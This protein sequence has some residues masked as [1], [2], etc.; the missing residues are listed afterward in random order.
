MT[1][2]PRL[3]FTLAELL[4]EWEQRAVAL[5]Q[6]HMADT[7]NEDDGTLDGNDWRDLARDALRDLEICGMRLVVVAND[8]PGRPS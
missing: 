3:V 4:A 6:Q 8:Q 2:D 1:E 5:R 7:R